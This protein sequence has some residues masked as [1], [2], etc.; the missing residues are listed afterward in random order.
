MLAACL[1]ISKGHA[2]LTAKTVTFAAELHS[3]SR[4]LPAGGKTWRENLYKMNTHKVTVMC[5]YFR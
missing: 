5:K 2:L 3:L 4:Q 1:S